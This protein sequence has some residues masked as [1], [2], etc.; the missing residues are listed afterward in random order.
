MGGEISVESEVGVGTVFRVSLPP[1]MRAREPG[2]RISQPLPAVRRGHLLV[3]DDEPFIGEAVRRLLSPLHEVSVVTSSEEALA[4]IDSGATYDV[5]LCDVM[6]PRMNGVQLHAEIA[7]I[8]P[9]LA[10]RM[11]FITGGAFSPAVR[12]FLERVPGRLLEKPFD[13]KSLIRAIQERIA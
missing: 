4:R 5:I 1:G 6:M 2:K 8:A 11:L 13:A 9:G 10:D 12:E 7:R 3:V